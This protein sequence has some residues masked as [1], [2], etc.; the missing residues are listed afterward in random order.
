M[1]PQTA[2]RRPQELL[3]PRRAPSFRPRC[4]LGHESG[5]P[6]AL[7][8]PR[9]PW[10]RPALPAPCCCCCCCARR[11]CGEGRG[12]AGSARGA[13]RRRA[14]ASWTECCSAPTAPTAGSPPCPPTSASSPPTCKCWPAGQ[15][16]PAA[17]AGGLGP[18]S[19]ADRRRSVPGEN[20]RLQISF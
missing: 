9:A 10:R 20:T 17:A 5:H 4:A 13:V 1:L 18:A 11:G 16:A 8:T 7:G 6:V 19:G 15:G 12:A 3:E 14:A 2:A